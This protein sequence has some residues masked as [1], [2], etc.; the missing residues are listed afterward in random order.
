MRRV[1]FDKSGDPCLY[2]TGA[3]VLYTTDNQPVGRLEGEAVVSFAGTVV[4]W[5][6]ADFLCDAE[7]KPVAFVKG[8]KPQEGL[9]LPRVKALG[10]RLE[11]RPAPFYPLLRPA[12]RPPLTWQWSELAPHQLFEEVPG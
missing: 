7:G 5:L 9:T 10:V 12:G 2:L 11:P 1:L 8:A 3:G 6:I 4:A